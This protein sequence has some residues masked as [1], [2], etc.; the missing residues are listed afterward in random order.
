MFVLTLKKDLTMWEKLVFLS[1][2][3][4]RLEKEVGRRGSG[5]WVVS[6]TEGRF[7]DLVIR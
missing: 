1:H 7:A 3:W 4:E 2:R 5:P 6:I